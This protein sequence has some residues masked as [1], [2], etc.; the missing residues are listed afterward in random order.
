V[1]FH[2]NDITTSSP[3]VADLG[4]EKLGAW[5]MKMTLLNLFPFPFRKV[6]KK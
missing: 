4:F 2:N 1:A 3:H 6:W 5:S